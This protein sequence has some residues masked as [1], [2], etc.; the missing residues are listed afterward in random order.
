M[1]SLLV[2]TLAMIGAQSASADLCSDLKNAIDGERDAWAQ[3]KAEYD[4]DLE[5]YNAR[6]TIE[7]FPECYIDDGPDY[8][9]FSCSKQAEDEDAAHQEAESLFG[10]IKACLGN[11]PMQ[12]RA[13][14]AE[15]SDGRFHISEV[16]SQMI[17]LG[18][19]Q[20]TISVRSGRVTKKRNNRTTYPVW[21]TITQK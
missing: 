7:G 8:P 10:A 9:R 20:I 21:F 2:V 4:S 19:E 17:T 5:S 15:L 1:K 12:L 3:Y 11:R 18:I 16:K 6:L 13:R 14:P